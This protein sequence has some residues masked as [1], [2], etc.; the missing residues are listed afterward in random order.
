M[1]RGR[2][3]YA[4]IDLSSWF[5]SYIRIQSTRNQ[6]ATFQYA[7]CCCTEKLKTVYYL[8]VKQCVY[9]Y[10]SFFSVTYTFGNYSILSS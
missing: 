8:Y 3:S 7:N 4:K 1:Y 10:Y 9:L 6:K 5:K 2:S